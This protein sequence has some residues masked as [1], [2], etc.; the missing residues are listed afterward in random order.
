VLLVV[1]FVTFQLT[2]GDLPV[3]GGTTPDGTGQPNILKTPTPSNEVVVPTLP[4]EAEASPIPGTL[5]Y[6]K[7][8]NIWLQ[9]DGVATQLTKGGRDSM[10]TFAPDGKTVYFVR[11]RPMKGRWYVNGEN[12]PYRMDVPSLMSIALGLTSRSDK[13]SVFSRDGLGLQQLGLYALALALT[14]LGTFLLR[15]VLGTTPLSGEQW[16]ICIAFSIGLVAIEEVV[17][18]FLRARSR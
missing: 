12:K 3:P 15:S 1:A 5:L 18:L 6:A 13:Q 2:S 10:P 9:T 11:T 4:P 14:F 8:G 7:D 16:G 17:K